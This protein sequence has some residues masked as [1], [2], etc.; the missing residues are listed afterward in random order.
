[1]AHAHTE[2]PR[3]IYSY[4]DLVIGANNVDR[5][6]NKRR[7]STG[8]GRQDNSADKSS[9]IGQYHHTPIG[10]LCSP[11]EGKNM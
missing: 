5:L 6:A 9:G 11:I 7:R 10:S 1:M 8:A 4:A 3:A 2:G